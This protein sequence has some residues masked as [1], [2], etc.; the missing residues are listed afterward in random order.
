MRILKGIL[1]FA[2]LVTLILLSCR[3]AV[4]NYVPLDNLENPV[5]A[6]VVTPAAT[7]TPTQTPTPTPTYR[8][9]SGPEPRRS[10]SPADLAVPSPPP[11]PNWLLTPLPPAKS[12]E[13]AIAQI[14]QRRKELG[15]KPG[16]VQST[17]GPSTR[18]AQISVAGKIIKLPDNAYIEVRITSTTCG[19]EPCLKAPIYSIIR[20]KS[21]IVFSAVDGEVDRE[22]ITPGEEGAFDF[23]KTYLKRKTP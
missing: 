12:K 10:L 6:Q 15:L 9:G 21:R 18:G 2:P 16:I 1:C 14:D 3:P 20:G 17:S 23:M 22:E 11:I 7:P 4:Q 19:K 5:P 13:E 8:Y